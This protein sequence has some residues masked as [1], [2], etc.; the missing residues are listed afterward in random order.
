M[1]YAYQYVFRR[2]EEEEVLSSRKA[3]LQEEAYAGYTA[4]AK[5]LQVDAK[6]FDVSLL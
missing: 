2:E 6:L 3:Y 4:M 5:P 1:C